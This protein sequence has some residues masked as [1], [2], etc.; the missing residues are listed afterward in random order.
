M[1]V[2]TSSLEGLFISPYHK[3]A[4]VKFQNMLKL[5]LKLPRVSAVLLKSQNGGSAKILNI[6]KV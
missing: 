2:V 6:N 3:K 1:A 4:T 5:V